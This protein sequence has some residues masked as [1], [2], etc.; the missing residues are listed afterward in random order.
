MLEDAILLLK[1][2]F[3]E[4]LLVAVKVILANRI[5]V[6]QVTAIVAVVHARAGRYVLLYLVVVAQDDVAVQQFDAV[7]VQAILQLFVHAV[8]HVAGRCSATDHTIPHQSE[9]V[10]ERAHRSIV[11]QDRSLVDQRALAGSEQV[12]VRTVARQLNLAVVQRVVV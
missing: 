7:V 11:D 4:S 1:T 10:C 3:A 2:Q 8:H 9:I 5:Q 12:L 6:V